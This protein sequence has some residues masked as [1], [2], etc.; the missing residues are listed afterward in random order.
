MKDTEQ[1]LAELVMAH[2]RA[3]RILHGYH[4]NYCCGGQR[5]LS[6]ACA[7]KKIDAEVVLRDIEAAV[8]EPEDET[9]WDERPMDELIQ[10]ILDRYHTPLRSELPRLLELAT[11]VERV[12]AQH[13]HC[14]QGLAALLMEA[15]ASIEMHLTKEEQILFPLIVTGRGAMAH[16]PV[17]VMMQEHDDHGQTLQRIRELTH[18]LNVP[19]K[20]CTSWHELYRALAEF[21]IELMDHIHL[22]NN[23]LF[24]RALAG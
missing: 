14:P 6:E 1:T 5:S 11:K 20:A 19:E 13:A 16:M 15:R 24:P 7:Q 2:P 4:L 22:E 9:F 8:F 12:H 17:Q 10:H 3:A 21:E 18:D 23:I